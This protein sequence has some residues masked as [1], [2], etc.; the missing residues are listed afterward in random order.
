MTTPCI[1]SPDGD[2][3]YLDS[4]EVP[5]I[6]RIENGQLY[7]IDPVIDM[8]SGWYRITG[9][10][11]ADVLESRRLDLPIVHTT[12]EVYFSTRG[13]FGFHTPF[14][15]HF[16]GRVVEEA[17]A[18]NWSGPGSPLPDFGP[19]G[20]EFNVAW[21]PFAGRAPRPLTT[22]PRQPTTPWQPKLAS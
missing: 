4:R 15:D 14:A 22:H 8:S 18:T 16:D 11:I 5:R 7:R 2:T 10:Q 21:A 6:L 9:F 17:I 1:Q 12:N 19:L 3:W 20:A 13:R